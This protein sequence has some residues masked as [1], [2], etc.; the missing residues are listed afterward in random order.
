MNK[1]FIATWSFAPYFKKENTKWSDE[2]YLWA[3]TIASLESV[4]EHYGTKVKVYTD[5]VGMEIFPMLTDKVEL[6]NVHDNVYDGVTEGLWAWAKLETY[7]MQNE[8]YVHIDLDFILKRRLPEEF[9]GGDLGGQVR[10]LTDRPIPG[11]EQHGREIWYLVYNLPVVGMDFDLPNLYMKP[12]INTYYPLNV[13]VL[14]MN[15]MEVNKKYVDTVFEFMDN[16]R[17]AMNDAYEHGGK[18]AIID[19]AVLEQQTLGILINDMELD[20]RTLL[21]DGDMTNGIQSEDF[22]TFCGEGFKTNKGLFQEIREKHL[23]KYCDDKVQLVLNRLN[24]MKKDM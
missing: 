7:K 22:I 19:I 5:S 9:F 4:Y 20:C 16:N 11:H 3:A 17:I 2:K 14:C 15:N 12:L 24:E 6:I 21:P 23:D 13:G 1:N 8:P 10:E 18:N